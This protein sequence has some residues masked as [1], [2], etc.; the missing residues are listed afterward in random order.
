MLLCAGCATRRNAVIIV[1]RARRVALRRSDGRFGATAH[2]SLRRQDPIAWFILESARNYY[3][4]RSIIDDAFPRTRGS[5]TICLRYYETPPTRR[6]VQRASALHI[7]HVLLYAICP[8]YC[9][10]MYCS[11]VYGP[12]CQGRA[13]YGPWL[14]CV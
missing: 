5:S 2:S 11:T 6:S 4:G 10:F 9:V 14:M 7:Y 8:P 1:Q 12:G 3:H 13:V